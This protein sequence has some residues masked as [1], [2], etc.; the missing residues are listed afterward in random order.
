MAGRTGLEPATSGSTVRS[1]NQLS[2]LPGFRGSLPGK[3]AGRT[4]LEPATSGSTV[5]SSN[6]LSYL[7]GEENGAQYSTSPPD[8]QAFFHFSKFFE[9]G[10]ISC[11]KEGKQ[12]THPT[13]AG[14]GARGRG[15]PVPLDPP[16][17]A[18]P[19]G[20]R[21]PTKNKSSLRTKKELRHAPSEV[22]LRPVSIGAFLH[23]PN[24]GDA[25]TPTKKWTGKRCV[26]GFQAV[27]SGKPAAHG[28]RRRPGMRRH[29]L[30][31][32]P[33]PP[34]DL[35]KPRPIAPIRTAQRATGDLYMAPSRYPTL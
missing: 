22:S 5:R 20:R 6:Q 19:R 35:H 10:N 12:V 28:R 16:K 25:L 33:R 8:M 30:T 26:D 31:R 23:P 17:G 1:S 29:P 27:P 24:Q 11:Q 4:G 21:A 14:R 7:P 32:K 13:E 9:T 15:N 3:M 2:Y 34:S 18:P